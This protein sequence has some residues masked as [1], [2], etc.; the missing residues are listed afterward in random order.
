M[1]RVYILYTG[2]SLLWTAKRVL[3]HEAVQAVGGLVS[4]PGTSAGGA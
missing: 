4:F 2:Q 3:K 1:G